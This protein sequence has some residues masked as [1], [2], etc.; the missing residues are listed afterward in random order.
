MKPLLRMLSNRGVLGTVLSLSGIVGVAA[1]QTPGAASTFS[2]NSSL[3]RLTLPDAQR[4]A[5]ERNWDLL[6]AKSDV[7]IIGGLVTATMLTLLILPILYPLFE[8][9]YFKHRHEI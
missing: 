5:F 4:I 1:Q 2:G 9:V 7:D 3:E 6:A 8:S